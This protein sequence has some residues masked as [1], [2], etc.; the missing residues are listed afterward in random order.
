MRSGHRAH[1]TSAAGARLVGFTTNV[2]SRSTRSEREGGDAH[3]SRREFLSYC[4]SLMR[5]HNNEHLD[6][7][8]ILDVS[9]LKHVA[10]VFDAL[11]YFMRS[12]SFERL[13]SDLKREGYS[14]PLWN[15]QD[16][17]ENEEAEDDIAVA[18][19]TESLEDQDVSNL[20][21]IS[22]TMNSSSSL[23]SG[24]GK[25][26]KHSFF[27]RSESTLCLGCPP[28]DP[29][30]TSMA[31][32]LP[33]ADQ[34]HLLQP[35]ARRE[36]LFGIPKQ[37]IT[38][39]TASGICANN[40]PLES[41]PTKL[42]LSTRTTDYAMSQ[43]AK[44]NQPISQFLNVMG[45][46]PLIYPQSYNPDNESTEARNAREVQVQTD[47]PQSSNK[48]THEEENSM[49]NRNLQTFESLLEAV[50][51]EISENS[52]ESSLQDLTTNQESNDGK[53]NFD[54]P[55]FSSF[56]S[57]NLLAGIG[58]EP[59]V[60]ASRP[61]I[62]VSPRKTNGMEYQD[63]DANGSNDSST[64]FLGRSTKTQSRGST[65]SRSPS[66]SVIVRAGSSLVSF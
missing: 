9:A 47:L 50:K 15:D 61:Q 33:L 30:E 53:R 13:D 38:L 3:V 63:Q 4:L 62:I 60:P 22:S 45:P 39:S 20:A 6:S 54:L 44:A 48:L 21:T 14:L 31:E 55:Q 57:P 23:Q 26:R 2:E 27:Q 35:N 52:K 42:S 19:E 1:V 49:K 46:N 7:L 17:N 24:S 28:P 18:M 5:A 11:I 43:P 16:E 64:D 37:P 29:F 65:S 59:E 32:A 51:S 41:L 36:D 8:P 58:L 25:G 56:V 40:S 34:P 12:G 10:Y 66:K